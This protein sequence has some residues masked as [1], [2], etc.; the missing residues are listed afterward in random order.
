M[1]SGSPKRA[2]HCS[3]SAAFPR[4]RGRLFDMTTTAKRRGGRELDSEVDGIA[5]V[6]TG[7]VLLHGYDPPA[8]GKWMDGV[9]PGKLGAFDRSTGERLWIAPCEVGYGRGFGAG[10]GQKGQVIVLGPSQGGHRMVRMAMADGELLESNDLEPFDDAVV[11][12]EVVVC[13]N[14]RSVW[15][16]DTLDPN[17]VFSELHSSDVHGS[18]LLVT[19]W[20]AVSYSC[21]INVID[22]AGLELS[23]NWWE[24]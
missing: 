23:R 20:H 9:I 13:A 15:G 14:A 22:Y 19:F 1:P 12:P 8:G 18:V 4:V 16:L 6:S 5:F 11:H 2:A 21:H 3:G 24:H 17:A 10:L 7:P